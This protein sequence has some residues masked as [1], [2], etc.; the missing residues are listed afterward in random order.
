MD[1]KNLDFVVSCQSDTILRASAA[2]R[3][4][5]ARWDWTSIRKRIGGETPEALWWKERALIDLRRLC[6]SEAGTAL[7]LD[8]TG[9]EE[10]Q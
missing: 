10:G 6:A 7:R 1:L 4:A 2:L 3:K 8:L 5:D 9:K